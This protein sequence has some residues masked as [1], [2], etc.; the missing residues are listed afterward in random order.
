MP[1]KSLFAAKGKPATSIKMPKTIVKRDGRVM[2][3][4]V[5]KIEKALE[6]CFEDI[7]RRAKTPLAEL[8]ARVVNVIGVKYPEP[9]VEQVQDT[10][11]LVLQSV[12]EFEAAKHYIL[13]R[14]EHAKL[15]EVRPIPEEVRQAFADSD[16]Y[17]EN[18]IQKFQY[19]DK[20][21]RF[22]YELGRRETWK[23]TVNRSVDFLHELS[24]GKL[25]ASTYERLRLGI[26]QMKVAPSMR[27]LAMAGGAARRNNI[28]I[29]NCSYQPVDS[30]DAFV[31]AMIISMNGCGVGYSV[32]SQYVENLPRVKRQ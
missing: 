11:E 18:Q 20:Y 17:F 1:K 10:V 29:Y 24:A 4:E 19:Y 6:L 32:E 26:L 12:G 8:S 2:P 3:F 23:E 28:C 27:L 25:P 22:N 21:A 14:A 30:L 9:S 16:V 31:E 5:K 15:R 13:Y 7:G